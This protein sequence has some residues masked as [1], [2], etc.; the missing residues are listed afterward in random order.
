MATGRI[1]KGK[2]VEIKSES[3]GQRGPA[4]TTTVY[5]QC[6]QHYK[7]PGNLK[8]QISNLDWRSR[9]GFPLESVVEKCP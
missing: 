9:R 7:F 3:A 2:G 5:S 4:G 1:R 6:I 8:S